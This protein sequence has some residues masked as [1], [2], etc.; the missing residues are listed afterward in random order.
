[1]LIL[2]SGSVSLFA[3][4]FARHFGACVLATTS[5]EEKAQRLHALGADVVIDYRTTAN[6]HET[7]RERT[8]GRGVDLVVES[9]NPGTLEQSIKATAVSGQVVLVGWLPSDISTVDIGAHHLLQ[10]GCLVKKEVVR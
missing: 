8:G 1:M 9:T 2:E 3:L 10:M 7:V 4:Q 5:S 6:W